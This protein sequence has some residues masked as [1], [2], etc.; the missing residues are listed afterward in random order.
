MIQIFFQVALG[1]VFIALNCALAKGA[2]DRTE[3]CNIIME[4]LGIVKMQC[5]QKRFS[6]YMTI[7][8][9]QKKQSSIL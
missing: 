9:S 8:V 3:S 7:R 2:V 5:R 6:F 1:L 4:E